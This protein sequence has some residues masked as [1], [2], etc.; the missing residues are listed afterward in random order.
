MVYRGDVYWVD[1]GLGRGSEQAGIRPALVVQ[2]NVGNAHAPTTIVAVISSHGAC[3][4]Y[5]FRV[6]LPEGLLPKS[7]TVKCEQLLTVDHCRLRGRPIAHLDAEL[8]AEVDEALKISLG[9]G[10]GR[11]G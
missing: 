9:L 11:L 3:K 10:T 6:S 4:R 2:N 8:M 5:P 1:F 7:S